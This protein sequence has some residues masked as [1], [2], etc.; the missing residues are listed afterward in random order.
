MPSRQRKDHRKL[1][2]K[3]QNEQ[4]KIAR[5]AKR[6]LQAYQAPGDIGSLAFDPASIA[7]AAL[8]HLHVCLPWQDGSDGSS[9]RLQAELAAMQQRLQR[10]REEKALVVREARDMQAFHQHYIGALQVVLVKLPHTLSSTAMQPSIGPRLPCL[11]DPTYAPCLTGHAESAYYTVFASQ[12]DVVQSPKLSCVMLLH[13]LQW[14]T[15][16]RRP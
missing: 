16:C 9:R 14:Q 3:R 13:R 8:Q 7:S 4:R 10:C 12:S 1:A 11:I 6:L 15:A 2:S 5:L